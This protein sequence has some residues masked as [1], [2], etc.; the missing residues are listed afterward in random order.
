MRKIVSI[1]II[2]FLSVSLCSCGNMKTDELTVATSLDETIM[3]KIIYHITILM[4]IYVC[5]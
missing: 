4:M 3:K 1:L 5:F 2:A